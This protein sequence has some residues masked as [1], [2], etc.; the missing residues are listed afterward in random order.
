LASTDGKRAVQA[1]WD[2]VADPEQAVP[3]LRQ[4]IKPAPAADAKHV[5]QLIRDLDSEDFETR[6]KA[7]EELEKFVESAEPVLRKKLAE[8]PSLEVRQRIKQILS[9]LE[10]SSPERLRELR[11]I[12]VL[13]YA[14]TAEAK[15]CLRTWVKDTAYVRL[16]REAEAALERLAKK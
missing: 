2:L 4:R 12:Q 1:L 6:T 5:E 16:T 8:K 3:L 14:D 7:T 15:E 10:P 13:E 11:A 9:K